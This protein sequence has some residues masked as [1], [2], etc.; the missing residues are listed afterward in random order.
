[1][2]RRRNASAEQSM[3]M[4]AGA[5]LGAALAGAAGGTFACEHNDKNRGP[6]VR[7]G[8]ATMIGLAGAF[9][10]ALA[11]GALAR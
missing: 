11:G 5:I 4:G 10:G 9:V 7:T 8:A 2:A 3:F 6:L 1:M